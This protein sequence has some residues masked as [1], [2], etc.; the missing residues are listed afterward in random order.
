[1]ALIRRR[2]IYKDC[3]HVN[4][5][6]YTLGYG[7]IFHPHPSHDHVPLSH[8]YS[9]PLFFLKTN[10]H[11]TRVCFL[12]DHIPTVYLSGPEYHTHPQIVQFSDLVNGFLPFHLVYMYTL[13]IHL[14]IHIHVYVYIHVYVCIHV[15][16]YPRFCSWILN[17]ILDNH[18]KGLNTHNPKP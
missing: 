18:N 14:Y 5:P 9:G 2:V 6:T 12:L 11:R 7:T 8:L 10:S 17:S 15:Y 3:I 16:I 4:I 1:M 13:H